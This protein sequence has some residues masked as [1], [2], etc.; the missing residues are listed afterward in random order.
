[1]LT[2]NDQIPNTTDRKT[3]TVLM[4]LTPVVTNLRRNPSPI[5]YY[6][7]GETI[8]STEIKNNLDKVVENLVKAH[9]YPEGVYQAGLCV[10]KNDTCYDVDSLMI[11]VTSKDDEPGPIVD[12][13]E[14]L[15]SIPNVFTKLQLLTITSAIIKGL[16]YEQV[17]TAINQKLTWQQMT[18]IY[19]G[20]LHHV[21][22]DIISLYADPLYNHR[23]MREIRE[24]AE[25]GLPIEKIKIYANPNVH[26]DV[27]YVIKQDLI[28]GAPVERYQNRVIGGIVT[29]DSIIDLQYRIPWYRF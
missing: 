9:E 7:F 3:F 4:L 13:D 20:Y 29:A 25:N 14:V 19:T 10:M 1:M 11:K 18:E 21:D 28:Q 5:I 23:Q 16:T 22:N 8:E 27:M 15:R 24:G 12:K 2:P 17:Q 6:E 26:E